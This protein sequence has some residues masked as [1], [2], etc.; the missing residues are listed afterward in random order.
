MVG[1]FGKRVEVTN[2]GKKIVPVKCEKCGCEYFYELSRMAKGVRYADFDL[3]QRWA[4]QSATTDAARN[5]DNRLDDEA[6]LV[7]CPQCEWV[8][9]ELV[10]GYRRSKFRN[11]G[12]LAFAIAIGGT[13]LS[14]FGACL[15]SAAPDSNQFLYPLLGG[16]AISFAIA[17]LLLLFRKS[18]R[19]T[20]QPNWRHPL[21][22]NVPI[23]TP[24][25]LFHEKNTGKFVRAR[26]SFI[27]HGDVPFAYAIGQ[28][29]LPNVC[30]VCVKPVAILSG[31]L[32]KAFGHHT[33]R[34]PRCE[35][36]GDK[37][38]KASR[39]A[40]FIIA[41]VLF[42]ITT[43]STLF[44]DVAI[45]LTMVFINAAVSL[46]LAGFFCQF[47]GK[48]VRILSED[49]TRGLVSLWFKSSAYRKFLRNN[50]LQ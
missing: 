27:E 25:A 42:L 7:P 18:Y 10:E 48:P 15:I 36:C 12:W 16:P 26:D 6:E 34:I 37:E 35:D 2:F 20:I 45:I 3:F 9:D 41:G 28:T 4:T 22:A 33:I 49:H 30:C 8:N 43:G 13:L 39:R 46:A 31:Y 17:G 21:P 11:L 40:F 32:C 23:H 5:L 14:L 44:L 38:V 29:V 1:Y 50:N 19:L 47:A 24:P